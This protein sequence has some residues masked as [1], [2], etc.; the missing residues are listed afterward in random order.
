MALHGLIY[1]E[2][3]GET[4]VRI[5]H[6]K[7]KVEFSVIEKQKQNKTYYFVDT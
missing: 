5:K 1:V 4:T 6:L 3:N 7:L 2:E